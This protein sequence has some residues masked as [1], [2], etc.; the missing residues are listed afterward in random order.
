MRHGVDILVATPGRLLDLVKPEACAPRRSDRSSSSTKPTACSTW[1]SSSDVRKHRRACCPSSASRCCSPPPCRTKSP[2]WSAKCCTIRRASR[3]RRRR[4]TAD[5]IEQ[6]VYH[7]AQQDKRALLHK[8]LQRRG[9]E[10][11]HRL[12]PHQARRQQRRRPARAR[13]ASR[14]CDP[15]QQV[16]ERAPAR[17]GK[18]PRAARSACSSPPTSPRAASTS[19]TS[20][21]SSISICRTSRKAMSTASAAPRAPARRHRDLV[22]RSRRSAPSARH[23]AAGAPADHCRAARPSGREPWCLRT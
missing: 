12:H 17:A 21:M 9:D 1:A 5:R 18:L 13:P 15:R 3:S 20:P 16:A 23:R 7:V 10:A 19:T 6:R 22:L 4:S 14:P 11:R 2:I 8:L